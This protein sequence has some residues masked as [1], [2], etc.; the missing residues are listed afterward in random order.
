[1]VVRAIR[2]ALY[3]VMVE[4]LP[5]PQD[6]R[7]ALARQAEDLASVFARLHTPEQETT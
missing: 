4:H 1:V 5:Q 6:R 3:G 2:H 7:A